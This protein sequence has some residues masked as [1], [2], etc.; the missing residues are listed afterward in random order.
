MSDRALPL[1]VAA[2]AVAWGIAAWTEYSDCSAAPEQPGGLV[3]PESGQRP[4]TLARSARVLGGPLVQ[5]RGMAGG[6]ALVHERDERFGLTGFVGRDGATEGSRVRSEQP[7]PR[8][9]VVARVASEA[10]L[11]PREID[12]DGDAPLWAAAGEGSRLACVGDPHRGRSVGLAPRGV[13]LAV[14][15]TNREHQVERQKGE[16]VHVE[17][18]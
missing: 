8:A 2:L 3:E 9:P 18:E 13:R 7:R 12:C 17:D 15:G 4:T 11:V 14:E 6:E 5:G 1:L 10:A 16:S